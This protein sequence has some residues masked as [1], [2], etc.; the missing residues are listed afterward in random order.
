VKPPYQ[1]PA[2]GAVF[3]TLFALFVLAEYAMRFRA[4]RNR[5]GRPAERWS[6]AVVVATIVGALFVALRLA[7][8]HATT[9]GAG[10]WLFFVLGLVLMAT[11]TAVR[12]WAVVVLG[13]YFTVEVRVQPGQTVVDRGPYRWVR[14]P[15][16]TGLIVFLV[17]VAD[18]ARRRADGRA[19]RPH[20]LR[21]TRAGRSARRGLPPLRARPAPPLPR[22][23]VAA[24]GTPGRSTRPPRSRRARSETRPTSPNVVPDA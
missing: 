7:R 16:Y 6:L 12:A 3:W 9:I 4:R 19:P 1:Q 18:R 2:A 8:W 21:G 24:A 23:L 17:G 10:R 15:A 14:H 13:R 11:G 22:R 5:V 20:P